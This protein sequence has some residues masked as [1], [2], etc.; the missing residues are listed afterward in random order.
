MSNYYRS[1][2]SGAFMSPLTRL[3]GVGFRLNT[4]GGILQESIDCKGPDLD[5]KTPLI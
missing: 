3:D 5:I 4:S 2:E 1:P